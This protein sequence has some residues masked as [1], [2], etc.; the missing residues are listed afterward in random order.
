M[1]GFDLYSTYCNLQNNKFWQKLT[2]FMSRRFN[3]QIRK[4]L[5][6]YCS[7]QNNVPKSW[8]CVFVSNRNQK[9]NVCVCAEKAIKNERKQPQQRIINTHYKIV[10][11]GAKGYKWNWIAS[12]F[13]SSSSSFNKQNNE[14]MALL[15][16]Q[17]EDERA[18]DRKRIKKTPALIT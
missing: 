5:S 12:I 6:F 17:R 16:W 3:N 15:E 4:I 10:L 13:K 18:A 7:R 8:R 9:W 14:M 1:N 11:K 2:V